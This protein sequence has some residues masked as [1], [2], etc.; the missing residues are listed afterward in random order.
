MIPIGDFELV[1]QGYGRALALEQT[2]HKKGL[3]LLMAKGTAENSLYINYIVLVKSKK[4]NKF[5]VQIIN[6][7]FINN[8]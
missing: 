1:L 3:G 8:K 5:K 7:E 2:G 6:S 4:T